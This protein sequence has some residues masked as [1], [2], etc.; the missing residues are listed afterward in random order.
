MALY[1][2][3][4]FKKPQMKGWNGR[5]DIWRKLI[6]TTDGRLMDGWG[7]LAVW[8]LIDDFKMTDRRPMDNL[9]TNNMTIDRRL[10]CK[11]WTTDGRMMDEGWMKVGRW[12]TT[13][14][15]LMDD[16]WTTDGRII[17]RLMDDWWTTDG[18]II[19]RLIDDWGLS[20]GRQMDDW[21]MKFGRLTDDWWRLI[22]ET[23]LSND[24]LWKV[25]KVRK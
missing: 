1:I 13:D 6:L 21:C 2:F 18:R 7:R 4:L 22:E 8:R 11:L 14:G 15:R 3:R 9:W 25:V 23:I 19:W 16:W 10:R 24:L 12:D 5:L 20:Y 17:W